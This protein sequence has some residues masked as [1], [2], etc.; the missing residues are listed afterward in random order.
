LELALIY[1]S[2]F[3]HRYDTLDKLV[4]VQIFQLTFVGVLRSFTKTASFS[5]AET[6]YGFFAAP[7]CI[8]D[9]DITFFIGSF[10]LFG[11]RLQVVVCF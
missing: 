4:L 1:I 10:Q 2:R 7:C 9:G 6:E 11:G 3:G 5:C 8:E